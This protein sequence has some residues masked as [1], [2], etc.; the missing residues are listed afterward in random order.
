MTFW[1]SVLEF[2]NEDIFGYFLHAAEIAVAVLIFGV[3]FPKRKKFVLRL[4]LTLVLFLA[5]STG[6]GYVFGLYFPYFRYIIAFL[7]SLGILPVC[8]KANYW[9]QLFCT[10]TA[11]VIQN[12]S[13]SVACIVAAACGWDPVEITLYSA[14]V[15]IILYV[16]VHFVCYWFSLAR[17]KTDKGG[18]GV[19]RISVIVLALILVLVVY[20]LQYNRQS[21]EAAN[22]FEWRAVFICFDLIVIF[23]FFYMY[24]KGQ[25]KKQNEILDSMQR[26][27]ATQYEMDRRSIELINI[28]CHDLKNQIESIRSLGV[29]ERDIALSDAE[30]AVMIYGAIAKTGNKSLDVLLSNKYLVCEKSGIRLTYV[31]DGHSLDFINPVDIFSLFGNALDNAI[32]AVGDIEDEQKRVIRM[33][34]RRHGQFLFISFENY[35][36]KKVRF[37]NGFPVTSQE[38]TSV[39]GYGMLSMKR[40]TE[41]YGGVMNVEFKNHIFSISI[42]IPI[43][44]DFKPAPLSE[45]LPDE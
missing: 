9:D 18:F 40:T 31:V 30:N 29:E 26:S 16:A 1:D 2:L 38:D 35:C 45:D 4:I 19:E 36:E 11:V 10:V 21:I 37:R 39:H 23:M 27:A 12:L 7:L 25:L 6:L 13:Y 33:E 34:C 24:D 20:I 42:T 15:E 5:A 14:P 17:L 22:Y 44:A 43:P 8:F 41:T 3:V 32:R 28:K